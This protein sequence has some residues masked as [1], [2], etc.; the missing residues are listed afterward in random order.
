MIFDVANHEHIVH[1]LEKNRSHRV[2]PDVKYLLNHWDGMIFESLQA[3]HGVQFLILLKNS[4]IAGTCD[5]K[6]LDFIV[7]KC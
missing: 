5:K 1:L 2:V 3:Q 6:W 7:K 4:K